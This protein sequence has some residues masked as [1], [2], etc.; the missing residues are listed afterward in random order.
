MKEIA[1]FLYVYG[2]VMINSY[3]SWRMGMAYQ[4]RMDEINNSTIG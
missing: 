1:L 3:V 2:I 4:R